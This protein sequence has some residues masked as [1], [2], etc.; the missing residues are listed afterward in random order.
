MQSSRGWAV[1]F[2]WPKN[3]HND[4]ISQVKFEIPSINL[5]PNEEIEVVFDYGM[6]KEEEDTEV[7]QTRYSL[8]ATYIV[9]Q[10]QMGREFHDYDFR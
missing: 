4:S 10:T 3:L 7:F 8:P 9:S 1:Y 6:S 2:S 5:D